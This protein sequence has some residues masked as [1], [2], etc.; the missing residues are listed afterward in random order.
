MRLLA[1]PTPMRLRMILAFNI[2]AA[3]SRQLG[4][5][6]E[7]ADQAIICG[8]LTLPVRNKPAALIPTLSELAR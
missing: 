7:K 4:L 8:R 5:T 6:F 1:S 2:Y 3:A